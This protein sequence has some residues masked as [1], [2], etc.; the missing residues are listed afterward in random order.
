[1]RVLQHA[2]EHARRLLRARALPWI[3]LLL[4]LIAWGPVLPS[5]AQA[6][7]PQSAFNAQAGTSGTIGGN[8]ATVPETELKTEPKIDIEANG[9]VL[10]TGKVTYTNPFFTVGVAEPLIILED[11][12]GFVDRNPSFLIPRA[13]QTLG[14]I[15]SDFLTSPFTYTLELPIEPQGTLRDVDQNSTQDPGV[16]VFAVAYWTNKFGDPFL[17]E[18]DLY[19]GG[20]STAY[21]S[22]RVTDEA[23]ERD[24]VIGGK[25]LVYAPTCGQGFPSGFGADGLLFT[26]DDP[27]TTIVPGYSVVNLDTQPFS[28]D[29]SRYQTVDLIEPDF[30]ALTDYSNLGYADAFDP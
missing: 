29:R 20:W 7:R 14:Q 13:S 6:Q 4:A 21:A 11:E 5:I 23:S 9:P 22:T 15:T 27:I 17:E 8:D 18:R 16:M 25:L 10:L 26:A 12:A 1:M 24:E 28:F 30:A 19:G 3:I 2:Y